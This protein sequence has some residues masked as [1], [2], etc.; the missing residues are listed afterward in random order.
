MNLREFM[1]AT[2]LSQRQVDYW[3][4][5]GLFGEDHRQPG[6]GN[7]RHY[8]ERLV[9]M[10]RIAKHLVE[11]LPRDAFRIAKELVEV[12]VVDFAED[13][14]FRLDPSSEH[15]STELMRYAIEVERL[16]HDLE[17]VIQ[18]RDQALAELRQIKQCGSQFDAGGV[19]VR[20]AKAGIRHNQHTNVIDPAEEEMRFTFVWHDNSSGVIENAG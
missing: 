16:T 19:I 15:V 13:V 7:A 8:A 5:M 6:S 17:H 1:Q 11:L 4:N 20:C 14:Q 2:G 9:P 10:V 18:E 3:A 12:G